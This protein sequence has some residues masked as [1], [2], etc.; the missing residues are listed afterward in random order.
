M[1]DEA[2][3]KVRE[4]ILDLGELA[5]PR[6]K[7]RTRSG[8]LFEVRTVDELTWETLVW[9][10]NEGKRISDATDGALSADKNV[11]TVQHAILEKVLVAPAE[12]MDSLTRSERTAIISAVFKAPE[13]VQS[14]PTTGSGESSA[15]LDG[16]SAVN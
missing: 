14:A 4:T 16:S 3:S 1:A 8:E 5:P 13:P 15:V 11:D 10:Q 2:K 6:V 9:I 7:V 12:V